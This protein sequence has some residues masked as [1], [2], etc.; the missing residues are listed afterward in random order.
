MNSKILAYVVMGGD[1][2]LRKTGPW[3]GVVPPQAHAALSFL[4]GEA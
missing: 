3:R 4:L 2:V 1:E